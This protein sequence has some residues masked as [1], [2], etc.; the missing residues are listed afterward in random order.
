M[1][2]YGYFVLTAAGHFLKLEFVRKMT[3]FYGQAT[4]F[5]QLSV[6]KRFNPDKLC[7]RIHLSGKTYLFPDKIYLDIYSRACPEDKPVIAV[8]EQVSNA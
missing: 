1:S 5:E 3:G 2:V 7:N 4:K 6:R 8:R